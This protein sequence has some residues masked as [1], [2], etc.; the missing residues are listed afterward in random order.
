MKELG[1][2][3]RR[4]TEL[5]LPVWDPG[6]HEESKLDHGRDIKNELCREWD[7]PQFHTIDSLFFSVLSKNHLH[8]IRDQI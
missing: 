8:K 7:G 1:Q 5:G 2:P 3:K 6:L 4:E